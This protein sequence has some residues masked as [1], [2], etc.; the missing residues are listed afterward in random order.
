MSRAGCPRPA[1]STVIPGMHFSLSALEN[2]KGSQQALSQEPSAGEDASHSLAHGGSWQLSR[3]GPPMG[4]SDTPA[5]LDLFFLQAQPHGH[6]HWL[7]L[8][9]FVVSVPLREH[10]PHII[11]TFAPWAWRLVQP[12]GALHPWQRERESPQLKNK[13]LYR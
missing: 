2:H 12:G 10:D 9:C 7:A 3:T 6:Q 13:R 11:V 8:C 5:P 1:I 4:I